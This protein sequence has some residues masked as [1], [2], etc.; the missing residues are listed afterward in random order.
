M[1]LSS[2]TKI[3]IGY[4]S[5]NSFVSLSE[6]SSLLELSAIMECLTKALIT[7]DVFH[8]SISWVSNSGWLQFL[9]MAF[10]KIVRAD[11]DS[12]WHLSLKIIVAS[13]GVSTMLRL[14]ESKI[15]DSVVLMLALLIER[16]TLFFFRLIGIIVQSVISVFFKLSVK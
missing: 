5:A 6:F 11:S 1:V 9:F 4:R 15:F 14:M 3:E 7:A 10:T 8:G 13:V 16:Y 12:A 2:A